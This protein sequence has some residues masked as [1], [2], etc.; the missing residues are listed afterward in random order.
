MSTSSY[1]LIFTLVPF[2]FGF[3]AVFALRSGGRRA[4]LVAWVLGSGLLAVLGVMDWRRPPDE[5]TP[6]LA[7]LAF[8][9]LPTAAA[10]WAADRT[11]RAQMPIVARLLI[12]GT[13]GWLA[14]L[15][16]VGTAT[17]VIGVRR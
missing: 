15:L 9:L 2:L 3:A 6:L 13:T 7:Y 12:A 16:L 5:G 1:A 11:A 8:A 17:V 14:I 10:A 4:L